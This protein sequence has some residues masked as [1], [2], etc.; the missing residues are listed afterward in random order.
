MRRATIQQRAQVISLPAISL[1]LVQQPCRLRR[2][3]DPGPHPQ[4]PAAAD[5]ALVVLGR[6]RTLSHAGARY[7]P[8][9]FFGLTARPLGTTH[10]DCRLGLDV[11]RGDRSLLLADS[12]LSQLSCGV[13]VTGLY[14]GRIF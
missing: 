3:L 7:R 4:H 6:D 11:I 10:T 14:S 1:A 9:F 5:D 13:V 2:P 12:V 8:C